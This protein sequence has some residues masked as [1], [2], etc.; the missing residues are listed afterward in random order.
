[1]IVTESAKALP[2][3]VDVKQTGNPEY[4]VSPAIP[5]LP[6]RETAS[7][8][9]FDA[10]ALT[11]L[12]TSGGSKKHKYV[13]LRVVRIGM[14]LLHRGIAV[15]DGVSD[16]DDLHQTLACGTMRLDKFLKLALA[17]IGRSVVSYQLSLYEDGI[18]MVTNTVAGGYLHEPQIIVNVCRGFDKPKKPEERSHAYATIRLLFNE[19]AKSFRSYA[20]SLAR[21]Q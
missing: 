19:G 21:M 13:K 6:A 18:E 11:A 16:S 2:P 8:D 15:P 1:M 5:C 10:F 7:D 4:W 9:R 20:R 17:P 14:T 12:V 3:W